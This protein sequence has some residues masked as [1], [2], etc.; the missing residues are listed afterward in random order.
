MKSGK[1]N[2]RNEHTSL[3]VNSNLSNFYDCLGGS[4]FTN[5]LTT[6]INRKFI[7]IININ[8]NTIVVVVIIINI[9]SLSLLSLLLTVGW[10]V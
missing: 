1:S 10:V 6:N 4:I 8:I 9:S 3:Q 5:R 7:V 2:R